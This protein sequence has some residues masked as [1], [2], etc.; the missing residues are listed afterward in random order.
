MRAKWREHQRS[1]ARA[2]FPVA[3]AELK[4][5]FDYL[6]AELPSMGCDHSR[7]ITE[8][9]IRLHDHD[10]QAVL[11]WLD[12]HGGFCDCE[13]LLNC[14]QSFD[15]AMRGNEPAAPDDSAD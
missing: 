12:D 1:S 10:A 13:V 11:T 7:R 14:E 6:D 8:T 3:P 4:A 5:L 15:E 9:W 2:A